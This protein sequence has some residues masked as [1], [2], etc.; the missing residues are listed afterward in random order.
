MRLDGLPATAQ[1]GLFA[2]SPGDL[3]LRGTGVGGA[4]EEVRF[5][6]AV[7]AFDNVAVEGATAGTWQSEPVGEMNHTDWEKHHNP[8]GAVE[9]NGVITISGTGDIG[10]IGDG[11][12]HGP[13]SSLSGLVIALVIVIV[14]AARHGARAAHGSRPVIAAR[15]V[16]TGA[17]T[18]VT[19]LVAVAVVLPVSTAIL[20]SNG[21][22]V[23]QIPALTTVRLVVGVAAV[24]ALCAVLAHA[25]GVL[26]RRGWA[27]VL[28]GL[29]LIALPFAVSTAPLLPDP[30]AGWLLRLT[31]AAAFAVE[32]TTAEYPQVVA[33][34]AP[35]AGYYPLPWW[36]GL[37]V[38]VAY[39]ALAVVLG[40]VRTLSPASGL[41]HAAR[42][43]RVRGG[44]RGAPSDR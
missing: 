12:A 42:R 41:D 31:P 27:A 13:E 33:H 22:A 16:I 40:N 24:L 18:F 23:Q 6:Q 38:L 32:Q 15:A 2:A 21:V 25:L 28:I 3:T 44:L 1:V 17:A 34:Y 9:K 5:T 11:A 8:S 29:S 35:S 10:P 14:V 37:I 43:Q 20:R 7:G 36:A 30:V 4:T 26:V 19:G 39:T